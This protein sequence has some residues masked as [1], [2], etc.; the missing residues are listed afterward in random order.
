[1]ERDDVGRS[2]ARILPAVDEATDQQEAEP[3]DR[4]GGERRLEVR[5]RS[6]ERIEWRAC[7]LEPDLDL[8]R[9]EPE[10][11]VRLVPRLAAR[12]G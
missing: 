9:E 6:L 2:L 8:L 10:R 12:R 7:V 3:P 1:V 4:A 5:C 11:D